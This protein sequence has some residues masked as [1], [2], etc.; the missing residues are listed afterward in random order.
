MFYVL[1]QESKKI[2]IDGSERVKLGDQH[3]KDGAGRQRHW[4]SKLY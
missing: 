1:M 4:Q 2:A 3:G